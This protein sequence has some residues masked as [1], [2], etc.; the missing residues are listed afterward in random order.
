MVYAISIL[1]VDIIALKYNIVLIIKIIEFFGNIHYK[2]SDNFKEK[3]I[4]SEFH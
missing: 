2:I 1:N 3:N 4:Y